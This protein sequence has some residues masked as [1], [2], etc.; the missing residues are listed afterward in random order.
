I[1]TCF[2]T[3]VKTDV[4]AST[5]T[6]KDIEAV[7][8]IP[9]AQMTKNSDSKRSKNCPGIS[10]DLASSTDGYTKFAVTVGPNTPIVTRNQNTYIT[11]TNPTPNATLL[12]ASLG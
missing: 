3:L 12:G 5:M 10:I 4:R 7:L 6:S 9:I 11:A 1:I 8:K 2:R